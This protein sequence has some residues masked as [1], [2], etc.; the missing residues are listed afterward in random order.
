LGNTFGVFKLLDQEYGGLVMPWK[1]TSIMEQ[2]KKFVL[3]AYK[4]NENF[5]ELCRRFGI[6]TKTGY[7]WRKRFEEHGLSGLE[8]RP[9]VAKRIRNKTTLEV[10]NRL[11]RIKRK[12]S[13]WGAKKIL[14]LYKRKYPNDH[15]PCRSTIED[16]L[17]REGYVK[18]KRVRASTNPFKIQEKIKPTKPNELW[19]VDFKGWWW[20]SKKER[21]EPLTVRDGTSRYILGIDAPEKADTPHVKAIFEIIFIRY[22]LPEIIRFDNGPPFGNVLNAWGLTKLSV[23]WMSMGIR[24]D[25][26]D[27]GRPDQNGAHERMHKDMKKELQLRIRGDLRYHQK[28]FDKWRKEFNEVRPHEALGMKTPKELYVKSKRKYD[29]TDTEIVYPGM[30]SRKV[31][32]RGYFNYNNHR[33][34]VGNP[35]AGYNIGIK[36]RVG[37]WTEVWFNYFKLG[38]INP[39]SLHIETNMLKNET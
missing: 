10:Q 6:S 38:V 13:S 35:F 27:P 34:F 9:P 33:I 31:N 16:I 26:I 25:R 30:R 14:V 1:E 28:E 18:K 32:D 2:K 7:K 24:L 12:Y 36:E 37:K 20:T 8:D 4:S 19:T 23:W 15:V 5:T 11:L 17:E 22:G 21:C 39:E 29:G 3:K